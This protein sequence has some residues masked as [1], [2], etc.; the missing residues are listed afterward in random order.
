MKHVLYHLRV[1]VADQRDIQIA[2]LKDCLDPK[3]EPSEKQQFPPKPPGPDLLVGSIRSATRTEILASL[4]S[5]TRVDRL[6][7][8]YFSELD[9]GASKS[10]INL[11]LLHTKLNLAA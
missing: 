4:P 3:D 2:C 8:S 7:E 10:S 1:S 5:R 11:L 6:V 9:M